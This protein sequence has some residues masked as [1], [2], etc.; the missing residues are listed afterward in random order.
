MVTWLQGTHSHPAHTVSFGGRGEVRCD[1][2]AER[3]E[4]GGGREE[5]RRGADGV[6]EVGSGVGVGSAGLLSDSGGLV[7]ASGEDGVGVWARAGSGGALW[8]AGYGGAMG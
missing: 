6:G 3:I 4:S 1:R 2:K 5:G 8:G 7:C